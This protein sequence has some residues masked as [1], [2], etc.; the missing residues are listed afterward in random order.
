M[1]GITKSTIRIVLVNIY[2]LVDVLLF[3]MQLKTIFNVGYKMQHMQHT[4]YL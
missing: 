4:V 3:A 2:D 1:Y